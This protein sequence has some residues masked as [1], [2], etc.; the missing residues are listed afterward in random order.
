MLITAL[1]ISLWKY[2]RLLVCKWGK[3]FFPSLS[4]LSKKVNFL[5]DYRGQVMLS[6]DIWTAPVQ[7]TASRPWLIILAHPFRQQTHPTRR[8]SVFLFL[9]PVIWICL[10]D[11]YLSV[12]WSKAGKVRR[13]GKRKNGKHI[14]W[15]CQQALSAH[16]QLTNPTE[17]HLGAE[18]VKYVNM[19]CWILKTGSEISQPPSS[20][21]QR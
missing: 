20:A 14:L 6:G 12:S 17:I 4:H 5:L 16:R 10:T 8:K 9:W 3:R 13:F 7:W 19:I 21:M 11:T 2:R 1:F 15:C 18:L